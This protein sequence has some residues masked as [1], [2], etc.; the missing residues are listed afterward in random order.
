[1]TE[2][3]NTTILEIKGLI[4]NHPVLLFMKGH[5]D[6]PQCGFSAQAVRLLKACDVTFETVDILSRPDIRATLPKYANWPTF[7]QLYVKQELVGGADIMNELFQSGE[8]QKILGT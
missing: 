5:P 4:E 2:E 1:M 7:P 8:L 3:L 6:F